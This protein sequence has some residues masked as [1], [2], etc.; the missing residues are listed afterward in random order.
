MITIY[1]TLT[2]QKE[3]FKPLKKGKVRMYVCGP[4][5]YDVP[6]I[7]HARSSYIFDWI[8]RYLEY[9]GFNVCYVR[10]IT[11]ID[12]KII[13][14]AAKELKKQETSGTDVLRGKVKEIAD[15]YLEV[16]HNQ[17][18]EMGINGPDLE[19]KATEN[20]PQMIEFISVLINKGY[21]YESEGNVYFSVE[22]FAEYGKL[23]NR[24]KE[25]MMCAVRIDQ[26]KR[27]KYPLDF[28]LW[29]SAKT[30]EPFWESPWGKGRPGWH[31]E[32]S[33]MSTSI[34]GAHFDIH[35]GGLDLIFPHHENEIAQAEAATGKNFANYWIHNGL[36]TVKN[37][38][39]AKSLGNYITIT[40]FLNKY[41][42]PDFLKIAFLNSHYRSPMDYSDERMEESRRAKERIIIFL[43]KVNK[44]NGKCSDEFTG[45]LKNKRV[46]DKTKKKFKEVMDDDFNTAAAMSVMFETVKIGNELL[47]DNN[48]SDCEKKA[49]LRIIQDTILEFSGIF[50]LKLNVA[51]IDKEKQREIE[52]LVLRRIEARKNKDYAEADRIRDELIVKGVVVEDTPEGP[53]W[54]VK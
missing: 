29:K 30:D 18:A 17:M 1:N 35:G 41:K 46:I 26:D 4:T 21:A 9:S 33:V 54:R 51:E 32:C 53:V 36:L 7:G 27:K 37:E 13:K 31:I 47:A 48:I 23:S 8:R 16:Y 38:K 10:N 43:D 5:V 39:M 14:R 49:N 34:F 2:R 44:L 42:D 12:D 22:K 6:H 28:A 52:E 3:E 20:I 11:D 15:Y 50:G 25:Q 19:P 24:D 40:D 45:M